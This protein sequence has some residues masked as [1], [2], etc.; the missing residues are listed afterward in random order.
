MKLPG[1]GMV[2]GGGGQ[3]GPLLPEINIEGGTRTTEQVTRQLETE[4]VKLTILI[5]VDPVMPKE[6]RDLLVRLATDLAAIDTRR[7]GTRSSSRSDRCRPRRGRPEPPLVETKTTVDAGQKLGQALVIVCGTLILGAAIIAFGLSRRGANAGRAARREGGGGAAATAP[8]S[9]SAPAGRGE[10]AAA[11]VAAAA[12]PQARGDRRV[13]GARGRDPAR[14]RPGHLGGRSV[15]RARDRGSRGARRGG[16]EAHR[17]ADPAGAARRD[18]ARARERAGA[19]PRP[20][21]SRWRP[22]RRRP[23]SRS[24]AASRSAA[25][26]RLAEFLSQ[27]PS[28]VRDEVLGELTARDPALAHAARAAMLL[29]E[30]LPRLT[31][32]SVRQVVAGID[33]ADA[34]ARAERRAGRARGR[35]RARCPSASAPSSRRRRRSWRSARRRRS[36]PPG[37]RSSC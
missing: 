21:R 16:R 23:S 6:R 25:P 18:R 35:A 9:T 33:P 11:A 30:D 10:A 20:R 29:F 27:T 2:E 1:F 5:F 19:L 8:S 32:P 17:G 26:S 36:R 24:G 14:A 34:R 28:A 4:V 12:G 31:D 15:H 3:G 13:Q 37:A 7:A 22:S